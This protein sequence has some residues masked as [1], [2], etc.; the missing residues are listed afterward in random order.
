MQTAPKKCVTVAARPVPGAVGDSFVAAP[1]SGIRV[2]DLS[3]V[4]AGPGCT[5]LLADFGAEVIK[6]G[7][8]GVGDDTGP[9]GPPWLRD[10]AGNETSESGY[11]LS[12]NRGKQ[13]VT[14]DIAQPEGRDLVKRLAALSDVFIENFKTGDLAR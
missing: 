11:Y 13:S 1:L 8:R 4:L 10:A 9:G 7:R 12:S 6:V 5:Q 3:R 2:L 14:L